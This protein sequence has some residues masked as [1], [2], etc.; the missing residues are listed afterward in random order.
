VFAGGFHRY[1]LCPSDH[2]GPVRDAL[3]AAQSIFVDA[4]K[5]KPTQPFNTVFTLERAT[6]S[7]RNFFRLTP[8]E[9]CDDRC[10]T[11]EIVYKTGCCV[12][13]DIQA[14]VAE[15]ACEVALARCGDETCRLPQYLRSATLDG[16]SVERLNPYMVIDKGLT[17]IPSVDQL[18][19]SLNPN[20]LYRRGRVIAAKT[21]NHRLR[22]F[23]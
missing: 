5:L 23:K 10:N 8:T 16:S 18:I 9:C 1:V 20:M 22:R 11:F 21:N 12:A 3:Y 2:I 7:V 13:Q 6:V 17:G 15:L 14:A 19:K 4:L